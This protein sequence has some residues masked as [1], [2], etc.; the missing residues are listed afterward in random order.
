M[1]RN[2]EERAVV[3]AGIEAAHVKVPVVVSNDEQVRFN[4]LALPAN[5]AA[6][7]VLI[8]AHRFS[9]QQAPSRMKCQ[10][11]MQTDQTV[12]VGRLMQRVQPFQI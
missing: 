4:V 11:L 6:H 12:R 5:Q 10:L 2:A 1:S 3:A 9:V 8:T 7:Q